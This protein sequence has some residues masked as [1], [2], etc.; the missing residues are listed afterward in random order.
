MP[1]VGPSVLQ[2]DGLQSGAL[3]GRPLSGTPC[4]LAPDCPDLRESPSAVA[5]SCLR[6]EIEI[7]DGMICAGSQVEGGGDLGM[8]A[9]QRGGVAALLPPTGIGSFARTR[10]CSLPAPRKPGTRSPLPSLPQ[11]DPYLP[12]SLPLSVPLR[13]APSLHSLSPSCAFAH[14]L[15][16]HAEG[17]QHAALVRASSSEKVDTQGK[18]H[19][20]AGKPRAHPERSAH[21]GGGGEGADPEERRP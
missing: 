13:L 1:R 15:F 20:Q 14:Q 21:T 18:R 3:F 16:R 5:D 10:A 9:A 7:R 11:A 12:P 19:R 4:S 2:R 6:V 17:R 8:A